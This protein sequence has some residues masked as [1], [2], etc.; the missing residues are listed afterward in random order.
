MG[1]ESDYSTVNAFG[2]DPAVPNRRRGISRIRFAVPR[3]KT[4][5][6]SLEHVRCHEATLR[7]PAIPAN[8]APG[9]GRARTSPHRLETGRSFGKHE[10]R[11]E[12]P[13]P[14]AVP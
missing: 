7:V 5:H 6:R 10:F 13:R 11:S 4:M 14:P 9:D 1:Q 8:I 2:K 3:R 12:P